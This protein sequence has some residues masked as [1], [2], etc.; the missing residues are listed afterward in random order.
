MFNFS[1]LLLVYNIVF[2]NGERP[3]STLAGSLVFI[4][5]ACVH[6]RKGV[7]ES[8]INITQCQHGIFPCR[9]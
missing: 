6:S 5:I 8:R 3:L 4:A 9:C 2:V 1:S 7:W